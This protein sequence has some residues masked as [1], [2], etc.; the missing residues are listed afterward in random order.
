MSYYNTPDL[1]Y[2][3][4]TINGQIRIR[5]DESGFGAQLPRTV[6]DVSFFYYQI[7]EFKSHG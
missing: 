7:I 1:P 6:M 2:T 3:T 5:T 4:T